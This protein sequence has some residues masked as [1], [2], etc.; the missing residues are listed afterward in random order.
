QPARGK[1][2]RGVDSDAISW[3]YEIV[4]RRYAIKEPTPSCQP[5]D[6]GPAD[7]PIPPASL[8]RAAQLFR[9]MGDAPRLHILQPLKKGERCV[10]AIVAAVNDKFSTVSQRL[11]VLRGEGLIVR[12]REGNHIYYALA[13]RH[14]ADLIRDALAHARELDAAPASFAQGDN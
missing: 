9:A 11:R 1:A 4:K 3:N 8:E 2:R 14:V 13:D 5:G 6:H 7:K 10:T 12:R